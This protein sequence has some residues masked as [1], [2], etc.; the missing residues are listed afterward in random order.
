MNRD[1]RVKGARR[2]SPQDATPAMGGRR[3]LSYL[4]RTH[5]MAAVLRQ[6]PAVS[7]RLVM[8]DGYLVHT[9]RSSEGVT[10]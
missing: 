10:S 5:W 9:A 3:R 2:R 8:P 6:R 4:N 7:G 1:P